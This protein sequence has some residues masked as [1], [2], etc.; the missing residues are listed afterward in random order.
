MHTVHVFIHVFIHHR[1]MLRLQ[2]YGA[3]LEARYT[4]T[5]THIYIYMY[6]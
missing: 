5:H 4:H 2:A 3:A 1:F 6:I